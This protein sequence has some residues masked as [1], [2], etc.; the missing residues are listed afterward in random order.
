MG[1]TISI[2]NKPALEDKIPKTS[3]LYPIKHYLLSQERPSSTPRLG[4]GNSPPLLNP[5]FS[6]RT[7]NPIHPDLSLIFLHLKGVIFLSLK[8]KKKKKATTCL[9]AQITIF[10]F[11]LFITKRLRRST[12]TLTT[13][14]SPSLT[15]SGTLCNRVHAHPL[16]IT[17]LLRLPTHRPLLDAESFGLCLF[18]F[19][20]R[21]N[22]PYLME[23]RTSRDTDQQT[24]DGCLRSLL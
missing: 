12:S 23:D 20:P 4:L 15:H 18:F 7:L 9:H 13:S 17:T 2:K 24:L 14:T 5:S 10:F 21:I 11:L 19:K 6:I 1:F 3:E 16:L 22:S 8:T